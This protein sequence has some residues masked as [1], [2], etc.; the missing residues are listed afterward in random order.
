MSVDVLRISNKGKYED[1]QEELQ[2]ARRERYDPSALV[3][4]WS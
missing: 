1:S 2:Y 4:G 3:M